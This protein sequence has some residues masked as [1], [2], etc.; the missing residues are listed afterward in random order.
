MLVV[1][2]ISRWSETLVQC[3]FFGIKATYVAFKDLF[4][5]LFEKKSWNKSIISPFKLF[6]YFFKEFNCKVIWSWGFVATKKLDTIKTFSFSKRLNKVVGLLFTDRS[7]VKI[8]NQPRAIRMSSVNVNKAIKESLLNVVI[9]ELIDIL[10]FWISDIKL[11]WRCVKQTLW[12]EVFLSTFESHSSLQSWL[13]LL[14][15]LSLIV[16]V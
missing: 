8:S 10:Q 2:L 15:S 1:K 5:I 13:H 11:K 9:R 16:L 6:Q 3:T 14:A 7:P 12:K 4:T